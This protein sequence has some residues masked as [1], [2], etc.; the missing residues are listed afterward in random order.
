MQ[1]LARSAITAAIG[2]TR[3]Q[4][5]PDTIDQD[6]TDRIGTGG[7]AT[8]H[9][10][11]EKCPQGNHWI[12]DPISKLYSRCL[13]CCQQPFFIQ[14]FA[15]RQAVFGIQPLD[16]RLHLTRQRFLA[17]IS[18]PWP[19]L[20]FPGLDTRKIAEEA[21]F[22]YVNISGRLPPNLATLGLVPV[23]STI[24]C[25]IT[26]SPSISARRG[27]APDVAE[28]NQ[29]AVMIFTVLWIPADVNR[30]PPLVS[31][32][33]HAD[34]RL[35]RW[36]VVLP[37]LCIAALI[38]CRPSP[39]AAQT[40]TAVARASSTTGSDAALHGLLHL[41]RERLLIMHEVAKWKWNEGQSIADPERERQLLA[42]LERR[43]LVYGLSRERTRAFMEAQIEA[44]K[45]V[46]E[47]D[48]A[49]WQKEEMGK[50]P[51]ARDLKTE[52]RPVIDDVSDQLLSQLAKLPTPGSEAAKSKIEDQADAVLHG[53]GIDD[54]VRAAALRP[55]LH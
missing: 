1:P 13:Q 35:Q 21:F 14:Q 43:G 12:V 23:E 44:G 17:T 40:P 54:A 18:H 28:Q 37:A 38:G 3:L 39:P 52:L 51:D 34:P 8:A 19:P 2:G 46:Q 49:A 29:A 30:I 24:R 53:D 45:L 10:L 42:D 32:C 5:A 55:L 27:Q 36:R 20:L 25:P 47:A 15:K 16:F 6:A 9:R 31:H 4:V 50:F 33:D 26:L 11:R 41:M 48:F 7:I 22:A